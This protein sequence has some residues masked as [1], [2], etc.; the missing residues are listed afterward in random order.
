MSL[1]FMRHHFSKAKHY[2]ALALAVIMTSVPLRA[3]DAGD[4]LRGGAVFGAARATSQT[5]SSSNPAEATGSTTN[6]QDVL[7]RTTQ[8]LRAVQAMQAA[9]HDAAVRGAANLGRDP[10]HPGLFLP[11]VPNGL[12]VGGLRVAP[13]VPAKL[14]APAPGED[15]S[16]WQGANL[17]TQSVAGAQ[18]TVDIKQTAQ[19][20]LLNWGTFNV[21]KETTVN[22]DQTSGGANASE[23]IAFNTITDPSGRPSQILGSIDAI[24]QVYL[25]NQN[26][27]IF[28]GSS[29]VNTHNL[30]ASSLPINTNLVSRGLLNNPDEQFLFSALPIPILPNGGTLPEFDPPPAPNTPSG[31]V[32]DVTVQAGA[33]IS[34][35]TTAD[36]VGGRV[37]LIGL[38]VTNDGT[39]STPDGQAI[40]A[41]G[42]QVGLTAHP[43]TDPSLRGLDVYIGQIGPFGSTATNGGLIDAPR[44]AVTLAGQNVAQLGVINSSTSVSLNGRI[45]LLANYNSVPSIPP[46]VNPVVVLTPTASGLVS[47]GPD[48]ITDILPELQ[49][50]ERIVG[51]QLALPSQA[52]LEGKVVHLDDN[53]LLVAPSANVTIGAGSWFPLNN[54]Y[55]FL[56]TDGQIY[57]DPGAAIDVAGSTNVSAPVSENFIDV[58]LRGAELANY[59]L[60][61]NGP[62]RGQTITID[63]RQTGTYNGVPWIG[64]PLADTSGY[65]ALIDRTV[66]E[67]TTGGGNVSLTAGDSVVIQP[68]ATVDVSGGW[69]NYTG[70]LVQTTKVI[71]GSQIFDI[72]QAT[73][74]RIY[75]GIYTGGTENH[76][77]WGISET[78]TNPMVNG[79]QFE[80]GYVQGGNGG[81][82]SISAS[83]MALDGQLLGTTITGPRQR[84][85]P[86]ALSALSLAFQ[87]R[88]T[89]TPY[90]FVAPAPP[91]VTFE[92]KNTLAPADP[93]ALDSNGLPLPL[94][95][96]RK[97]TVIL[98][99]ELLTTDGF[100]QLSITNSDGDVLLPA[101]V[102]LNPP[103]GGS[104]AI[105]AANLDLE[106]NITSPGAALT[107]NVYDF[108]PY[109]FAILQL[110]PGS[111]APPVDPTRGIFTLGANA[112]LDVTG[113]IADDR[114]GI[115]APETFPLVTNGGTVT[116]KS[117]S[118]NLEAGSKIDVSGGGE[119][120]AA[121]VASYGQAGSITIQAGQDLDIPGLLGGELILDTTLAGF[122]GNNLGGSLSVLA[123]AIQVGGHTSNSN[124]LLFDPS[125]FSQGGFAN[126]TLSGLGSATDTVDVYSPAVTIASGTLIQPVALSQFLDPSITAIDGLVL[127]QT[128]LPQALRAPVSLSFKA[129]GVIDIFTSGTLLVRGDFI[130]ENGSSIITDPKASVSISGNTAAVLGTIS[131]P[132]GSISVSGGGNSSNLFLSDTGRA[133]PTVDLGPNSRLSAAGTTLLTPNSLG[134][135][136][137]LVL[138]GGTITISGNIVAEAGSLLDVSGATDSLDVVPGFIGAPIPTNP[139]A[140]L[141]VRTR[142]DSG[143]GSITFAG[144][145]ELFSD[146]TLLGGPGGPS[147]VGGSLTSSSGRFV[148]PGGGEELTPLDVNLEVTQE[149]PVIPASFYDSGQTAIGH[150]VVDDQG[151][152]IPGFGHVAADYF[153]R[154][155]LSSLV[156]NGTVGFVGPVTINAGGSLAVGSSGVI[157]ADGAVHLNGFSVS[158]GQAFLP[159][160]APEDQVAPFQIGN[161]PFYFPPTY[162]TGRLNV[163]GSMI[164]IG[165][166]SL[167][168]IGSANLVATNGDVRGDGTFD[169]A[170]N[171]SLTAGQIYPP[172]GVTFNI[173]A[174]DYEVD[175]VTNSGSITIA[176]AGD[177]QLPLSAGGQL[178]VFA[179]TINQGGILRAPI[180]T[181]NVGHSDFSAPFVDPI[182]N[183]AFPS[184]GRLTVT[185]ASIVSVSAVD[186]TT[187]QVLTIPYGTNSN[188]T[189]W[190]D[191]TGID[192]TAGGVP[193][194]T[195]TVSA[196]T[197][198]DETGS[199][200]DISGGGDLLAYR[201]V[202]GL[203][204]TVDVLGST[205]SF[206]IVPGYGV[207]YAPYDPGYAN[208]ALQPGDQIYLNASPALAAGVYTLL[209]A[210]YALLPGAVL[211]TA[212]STVP[213]SATLRP[214]GSSLVSGYRFNAFTGQP[215][216]QPLLTAFEVAPQSVVQNRADYE[217]YSANTFLRDGALANDA[218]APRLPIDSGHLVLAATGAVAIGGTVLADAPT[219][220]RRGLVDINTPTDILIAGPGVVAP[221]G[222]LMLDAAELSSF[223][224][225]SLLVG[226][227]REDTTAGTTVSVSTDNIVVNNTGIPLTG[228]GI[229]LVANNSITITPGSKI[230]ALGNIATADP[231]LFGTQDSPGSGNGVLIRVSTDSN[232][233]IARLGVDN[234]TSPTL[235]IG[236]GA[237]I[238]GASVTLDSTTATL[239]DPAAILSG[240]SIALDSGQISLLLDKPGKLQATTGLVLSGLALASLQQNAQS[241]TLLS[242]SSLDI[243]G[244]GQIGSSDIATLALHAGN[245]RGF[246]ND[247]GTVT[248]SAQEIFVDNSSNS[249]AVSPIDAT[250]G[251]LTFDAANIHFGSGLVQ[252][253]QFANTNLIA[254]GGI[255]FEGSG[256]LT[257]E[258]SVAL[259]TPVIT[260]TT[261]AGYALNAAGMLTID[262]PA[263]AVPATVSGGLGAS[264][265]LIGSSVI[266]NSDILLPSGA[267]TLQATGTLPG[268]AVK[269]G[270]TLSVAGTAQNFFDLTKYTDAGEIHL[271]A[272]EGSVFLNPGSLIT[273]A[274]DAGGGNAGL[275]AISAPAGDIAV[276]GSLDGT[277]GTGGN[278]SLDI[279]A[280]AQTG[281]LNAALDAGGFFQSRAF[282]IRS[283]DVLIDGHA[284]T[285]VFN[286]SADSGSITVKGMIDAYSNNG[287]T[288]GLFANSGITLASGAQLNVAAIEPDAAG[289]AGLVDLETR[290][291]DAGQIAIQAGSLINL[292]V[293]V[294]PGGTLH[295]RAPQNDEATDFSVA[296]IDGTI[297]N[298]GSIIAEA[299]RVFDT[300]ITGSID[301]QEANVFGNQ[302]AVNN[303]ASLI[304]ARVLGVNGSFAPIFH[305]QQGAEIVNP[306]GDLTLNNDW[307]LSTYRSGDRKP[308][309]DQLGNP[310]LDQY[311]NPIMAGVEPGILTL[312]AAGSIIFNGALTDGFGDSLG[313]IPLDQFGNPA[314]WKSPLLPAFADGTSQESWGYRITAGADF[315]AADYRDTAPA[316][317]GQVPASLSLGVFGGN[318]AIGVNGPGG[319]DAIADSALEGHYQVIRTGTGD[320]DI[321][322]QSDIKLQNPFATIYTAGAQVANSTLGGTFD[323]PILDASGGELALGAVQEIPAYPAQYSG[324][325]GHVTIAA[326]GDISH[327][328]M[329]NAGNVIA[330]SER[331]LP[332]NWLYRR[333]YVDP[334]TGEF[335]VA[336]YG[337][338]ASTSWWVDFANFF[339]GVGALGGGD[340]TMT[341][342][343]DIQNVDAV[344]P[345]NARL[346]KDS[347]NPTDLVELGGGN[348]TIRAGHDIDGGV[349]YVERG[350]GNLTAGNSIH[351]NS[352]RSP[353][354][355]TITN[356]APLPE[357]TWLPTTLFLGKGSY[358]V[359]ANGDLTLGPVANPFLLP[360]GYSN[361]FWYKTYFSTYATTDSVDVASLTGTLTL[362][363]ST[364]LPT[365]V[366]P[367]PFLQAWEREVLLLSQAVQTPAYYQPWLRLDESDVSGFSTV[368]TLEPGTLRAT[369]FSGDLNL[370]GQLLLSPAPTGTIDLAAAGALNGLQQSGVVTLV[371]I[372]TPV[373]AF[374]SGLINLS[375]ANPAFIP[376]V[377]SPFAFQTVAGTTPSA[378]NSPSDVLAFVNK[379][380]QE[381][382]SITGTQAVLQTEQ[383]LHAAGILHADDP[384]PIHLYSE[385]GSISGFTL[386][387][388]KAARISAGQDLTDLSL[389]IQNTSASDTSMVTAGRDIIAYDP[390][391]PLRSA[392]VVSG[393]VLTVPAT[394]QAGDVQISG[395]GAIEVLAGRNLNLGIGASNADG[396]GVGVTSIGN[397]RN[398]FLPFAGAQIIGAAGIGPSSSL[399]QSQLDFGSFNNLFLNPETAA[400]RG[401]RYLPELAP[402][403]GLQNQSDAA[404]WSA[405]SQLPVEEQDLLALKIFYLVLRDAARD[406]TDSAAA[407]FGTYDA[408]YAAVAALFPEPASEGSISLASREIATSSG[409]DIS[410]LAPAGGLTVGFAGASPAADQGL[411]T[412]DGGNIGIFTNASVEVGTSRIFTLRGGN[413]IIWSTTGDIAA[414]ASSKTVQ[415]APPTRV[416]IDPQSGDVKT[417]LAGLA[418]GGGIGVLETVTGVPPGDVD[419]IAPAGTID[420]GDAGI[421]VSGNLNISAVQ[422]LNAGNIAVSGVSAGVPTVA[423]PNLAGLTAASNT[424]GATNSAAQAAATQAAAQ[425]EQTVLP[426]IVTVEVLGYGNGEDNGNNNNNDE[427]KRRRR[428]QG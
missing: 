85:T 90:L 59:S 189:A 312:R 381:S 140:P 206:A 263:A 358:T 223:N 215:S 151:E 235:T 220:G 192:I 241:L 178:N 86:P 56:P 39:I 19:Q 46:G 110:T 9:A 78:H 66:G 306:A 377:A 176:A 224:A 332:D 311:G 160:L 15:P 369:A 259:T 350:R 299:Y 88:L 373:N 100:G 120:N 8:A 12:T 365:R 28:G 36:H 23:W 93:F 133:L 352:T 40:L 295:L 401:A 130:M 218:A 187:G 404:V 68:G 159:P 58:Q 164:D 273:V 167:Q 246:N 222:T 122:G 91:T 204:G 131:A 276:S 378:V 213:N 260:G 275:L 52:N 325:G 208:P 301:S 385:T 244:T 71:S 157:Y 266:E 144:A 146:A 289:K 142:I 327:I 248:L 238:S 330:D 196:Q 399:A 1:R 424:V 41:A 232:A 428:N 186:P 305:V 353:S 179:T 76:P 98:S 351:T 175:G 240:D 362:R 329:D 7:A 199:T 393:N 127:T 283:G 420:A 419:L 355:T 261:G 156:L 180:G 237:I 384:N 407:A 293:G 258:G 155:G 262:R 16:L 138:G 231:L 60:Q 337:D 37:A 35:P 32:G 137:G 63:I 188:G 191:P 361:T 253:D 92:D 284:S 183:V 409:G 339:E 394:P 212:Q 22:F 227:L 104:I 118:A 27:I 416:L 194:K 319:F 74:D 310:L 80:A 347:L 326:G 171:I 195:I 107:F 272:D 236:A 315:Q 172:T 109:Q 380:F 308:V 342:G 168:T 43:T 411:L 255:V 61:R 357:D 354:L 388:A 69:I 89:T 278:F 202:P 349:Y 243:Y 400:D 387:S 425:P 165:N 116:I 6:G 136:T 145:Q 177:R 320:I 336:K 169:V 124:T 322:V 42:Q 309:V 316:G 97:A 158:L 277:G 203:G 406:R 300:G 185:P 230:E 371:N 162:G 143:G 2:F 128:L 297:V 24:G 217:T 26:G 72:S 147:A 274:A 4:I 114:S 64:T 391:S 129:P 414:G 338:V 108:S 356:V 79:G 34:S 125:F 228:S 359:R 18:T 29:Q 422:V 14:S 77:K 225:E 141:Y 291:A 67:L 200:V 368:A 303:N 21:G 166:L 415:S 374:T 103:A 184:S 3:I 427:D 121:N 11:N 173:A 251:N 397:A 190:I 211:V 367:D 5:G 139:T 229:A 264:L 382:G 321:S 317:F 412:E 245:I 386:F 73:P 403:L 119:V 95:D 181:I 45:D 363:D 346:P 53:A 282:R 298:P 288:I 304:Q 341:A 134:F 50:D 257:A 123:P 256:G 290:G 132:A 383:A 82:L 10:N 81:T 324:G 154:S 242:Y 54:G 418:T 265:T 271:N 390:T 279:K 214:D 413:E 17:P 112:S 111:T 201:F 65:V 396:T 417:D 113:M 99:P 83:S 426:S 51:T 197:L 405:F 323:L 75:S 423:S 370:V 174:F 375:D 410:L 182:S 280:F 115:F 343:H 48:S 402:L 226:G 252:I 249:G 376:G 149:G 389:Y 281:A 307:D 395:P 398:P 314:R 13:G 421:R 221:L 285:M 234:S 294:G 344:I 205:T 193:G 106:G 268:S 207:A 25:I 270:G 269:I 31:L 94:R 340:V 49:S 152:A 47:L 198:I 57:L 102:S 345:T 233:S 333:G 247:G 286:L 250:R 161:Q 364:T 96:D 38:N 348:L 20:A 287:G 62:L 126:F 210:R 335:G 170:G 392:A 366:S 44:A 30:T 55:S 70:A 372:P 209:P 318:F 267:I 84:T 87:S 334:T 239:L 148:P 360:G 150:A 313:T 408:G 296:P 292:S 33:T 331:Q 101:G 163:S 153:N 379:L 328:A 216:T 254:S 219:G 135:R 302:I 105:S 117:Y